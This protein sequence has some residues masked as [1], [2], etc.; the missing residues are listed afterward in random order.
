VRL[1]EDVD[2][3]V[4]GG[5]AGAE[6]TGRMGP[7]QVVAPATS[8]RPPTGRGGSTGGAD[9]AVPA[10]GPTFET[11][12]L[13]AALIALALGLSVLLGWASG[14]QA[15]SAFLPGALPMKPNAALL[16]VLLGTALAVH[17]VG[18]RPRLVDALSIVV[19]AVSFATALEYA[20]GVELGIDRLLAS[21]VAQSGAPY[22]GRMALGS[23]IGFGV[24]AI[25]VLSLGRTWRGWHLTGFLALIV[26][27]PC[28]GSTDSLTMPPEPCWASS[29][30]LRTRPVC[31]S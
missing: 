22:P 3:A 1:A 15:L 12:A 24:G 26:A 14:Q 31:G 28:P 23:V 30:P 21:D 8:G 10:G 6:G 13:G 7:D 2:G 9:V 18:H 20:T 27:W 11:P 4:V 16:L 19:F 5:D 17:A 25:G 29:G